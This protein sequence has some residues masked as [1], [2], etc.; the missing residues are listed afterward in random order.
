MFV[1]LVDLEDPVE[2]QLG[3]VY[4]GDA[5][6]KAVARARDRLT[7]PIPG[8]NHRVS[9]S[10][11]KSAKAIRGSRRKQTRPRR[12]EIELA[13]DDPARASGKRPW[14]QEEAGL[15]GFAGGAV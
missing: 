1:Q 5:I 4:E 12:Q 7:C 15:G 3:F 2:D 13:L 10:D 9:S 6:R 11:L 8:T 14:Q